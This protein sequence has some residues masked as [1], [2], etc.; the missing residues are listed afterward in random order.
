LSAWAS[1]FDKEQTHR[2]L[3]MVAAMRVAQA[4]EKDYLRGLRL[5]AA[6]R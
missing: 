6:G 1:L 3:E 2:S 4:D 5:I